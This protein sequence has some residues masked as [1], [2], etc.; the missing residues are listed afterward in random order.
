MPLSD[1]Q[2]RSGIRSAWLMEETPEVPFM[3]GVGRGHSASAGFLG[4]MEA[5]L[6]WQ[7]AHYRDL[8]EVGDYFIPNLK[9]NL[10]I[11]IVAAA[12]GCE[13]L[14]D[15]HSDPWIRP[16]IGEGNPQDVYKLQMPDLSRP[17]MNAA[18]DAAL[19]RIT[20]FKKRSRLPMRLVNVPSPLV[21]ASLIW[22][23]T[24][25]VMATLAHPKEVHFLLE[26]VTQFTID[27]VRLQLRELGERLFSL[28]HEP[29]YLPADLG[30]RISDD[31]A[32]VMSPKGYREFGVPYNAR[33]SEAF[34]GIVV[35][36]CGNIA[37]VLPG[38]L[39]IPGLRG[40]D[41]VAP[42]NDWARVRELTH[43]RTCLSLRYYGSDFPDSAAGD[44]LA[45]SNSL[46]QFFGR[47]G[48]L[49]W[50]ETPTLVASQ[51]LSRNLHHALSR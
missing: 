10:G 1:E 42:Q 2:K 15:P 40:I 20:C 37:H 16:L 30:I 5:D 34:G 24:S 32:A 12:F 35:H 8:A 45:Y 3:V 9:P 33:I 49:F 31:T 17:A 25:F 48:I 13:Q 22:E 4:D 51:A 6:T 29:W 14:P 28:S 41:L 27:F 19:Q 23:Y 44:K 39:S 11:G 26:M 46:V 38:M 36:S 43:D 21:T 7:E 50:T 47:R 18:V